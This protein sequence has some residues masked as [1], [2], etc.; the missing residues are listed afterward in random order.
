MNIDRRKFLKIAGAASSAALAGTPLV[1]FAD[2][3]SSVEE[4]QTQGEQKS[5]GKWVMSSCQGCTSNCSVQVRVENGRAVKVQGNP[6]NKGNHGIVCPNA[7]LALQQ[8]Y[9][10]DRVKYPMRRT[11]PEKGRGIDPGF[12]PITWDEALDEI[13]DKLLEIRNDGEAYKVAVAKG[14]STGIADIFHKALPEIYGTPNRFSHS[15]ICAEAEKLASGAMCGYWDYHDYDL[16][17]AKYFIL[18]GTDILGSNRQISNAISQFAQMKKNATIVVIDPHMSA[19]AIKA[20]KWLPIIPGTDGACASALAH[21]ILKEG[22]W[23][24]EFVGDF[25]DGTNYFAYGKPLDEELW[26]QYGKYRGGNQVYPGGMSTSDEYWFNEKYTS[27][28]CRWWN[29][30]LHDKT[31][32]W[33]SE[34]CGID[35]EDIYQLARD[36]AAQKAKSISWISRGVTMTPRGGYTGMACFALNGL[37]GSYEAEGGLLRS[38][39]APTGHLADMYAYKDSKAK[40]ALK[41]AKVDQRQFFEF[42]SIE[43]GEAGHNQNTNRIA[44]AINSGDPYDLRMMISYWNNWVWSC[45]GT[46]RWEEALTKLPYFV[47]ITTNPSEMSQ[48]ADIV[49]PAK[50]H[51]FE[52]WGFVKNKMNLYAYLSIEQPCV[53]AL[54]EA[55]S[56]ETEIAWDLALK[57][58]EKGFSKLYDYYHIECCDPYNGNQPENAD[59]F[60]EN[61]VKIFTAP[62]WDPREK[63]GGDDIKKWN[64]FLK[65]GVWNSDRMTYKK[66]YNDFGTK[67]GKFEFFSHTLKQALEE[68]VSNYK[69]TVN[70]LMEACNYQARDGLAFVPHYEEPYRE[71]NEEQYPFIFCENRSRLNREGRSANC[72]WYQEFKDADP[73]DEAWDDVLKINPQDMDALGLKDGDKIRVSSPTGTVEVS[74]KSWEGTRPGVVHKTYGQGHWAYGNIAAEDYAKARP[75]GGNNNELICAQWE[76]LSSSAAFHGGNTRVKIEKIKEGDL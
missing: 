61:V 67:T 33:A 5:S 15:S 2:E 16:L 41:K 74:A 40:S 12:V 73:G 50:H 75:R 22:L 18:W 71:G 53:K 52:A 14:R 1:A 20:D 66:H 36:F 8:L 48:F 32:E 6:K 44:D 70:E 29:L 65:N 68:H 45:P 31:P 58:K 37:V 30:E 39:S 23:N 24:P 10:P 42:V 3:V 21:V 62:A 34:I 59:E 43:K 49:L 25:I 54:F 64:D 7:M 69:S 76:H 57:L 11:N 13:A 35:A 4:P 19:T 51:M 56:D 9:D 63:A 27:G 47:H 38:A 72:T 26:K 28:I 46:N 55:K 17:H 60:G